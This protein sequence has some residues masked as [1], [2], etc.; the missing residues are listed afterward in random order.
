VRDLCRARAD[1][2]DD[3]SRARRRLQSLLLRHGRVYRAG[4]SWTGKHQHWLGI[5]RF[6]DLQLQA[7]FRHYRWWRPLVTRR[8]RTSRPTWPKPP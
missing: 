5:Q 8:W 2:V 6:D 3:R 7:T 4:A 1:L